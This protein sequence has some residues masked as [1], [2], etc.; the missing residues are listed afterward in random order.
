[1]LP[2]WAIGLIGAAGGL[3]FGELFAFL[4]ERRNHR[5]QL[6]LRRHDDQRTAL[7]A[8]DRAVRALRQQQA[9]PDDVTFR[10]DLAFGSEFTWRLSRILGRF[11]KKDVSAGKRIQDTQE[12]S[13]IVDALRALLAETE[14]ALGVPPHGDAKGHLKRALAKEAAR[15]KQA[16]DE[17]AV[18]EKAVA[19]EVADAPRT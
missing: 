3:L 12:F 4:R 19:N 16:E 18:T 9:V 5:R 1:M 7:E 2:P 6:L 13:A 17:L 8:L 15:W 11:A 14:R 10:V